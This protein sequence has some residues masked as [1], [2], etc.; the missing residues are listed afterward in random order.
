MKYDQAQ[1]L[2]FDDDDLW[3]EPPK[4]SGSG[5]NK[6]LKTPKE[7]A[8]AVASS[9]LKVKP[10]RLPHF[11]AITAGVRE[12]NLLV[13]F[14]L[15]GETAY[16]KDAS[17]TFSI[18]D[19]T[20]QSEVVKLDAKPTAEN[21]RLYEAL[22]PLDDKRVYGKKVKFQAKV[23]KPE[24]KLWGESVAAPPLGVQAYEATPRLSDLAVK[25]VKLTDEASYLLLQARAR[26]IPNGKN[27][28]A[29]VFRMQEIAA[30]LP[31]PI[32][33][34]QVKFRYDLAK[35][36]GGLCDSQGLLQARIADPQ[37][38]S[39]LGPAL[40]GKGKGKFRL[41]ACVEDKE[42]KVLGTPVSPVSI[43][44][45]TSPNKVTGALV[46]GKVVSK[47]FREKLF[48]IAKQLQVDANY[49]MACMAFETGREF[50]ASTKNRGGHE[51]YGLIQFTPTAAKDLKTTVGALKAMTE[52]QQLDYVYQYFLYWKNAKKKPLLSLSDVYA[53]IICPAAIGEPETFKCYEQGSATN[54]AFNANKNL[55]RGKTYITKEDITV[56]VKEQLTLGQDIKY[57]LG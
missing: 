44:I 48:G 55:A 35:G 15:V 24:A 26:H 5:Q 18:Q 11:G 53:C 34:L 3:L 13:H 32:P 12:K 16:W 47:E 4:K 20:G 17:P 56:P 25:S 51:A 37:L 54:A 38:V 22:V 1:F 31:D 57:R 45:G 30:D 14:K 52:V 29:L 9:E 41:Q 49:L 23:S 7:L 28:A 27:G 33:M 42:G 39:V 21:P 6:Q 10:I 50:K 36:T 40:E 19:E 8:T 43:D 2:P 46:F